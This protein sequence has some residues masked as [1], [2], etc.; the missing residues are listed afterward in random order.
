MSG[1]IDKPAEV[2]HRIPI[3]SIV[4]YFPRLG[5]LGFGGALWTKAD[6]VTHFHSLKITTLT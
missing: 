1:A 4:A 3:T 6:S 2:P 5:S